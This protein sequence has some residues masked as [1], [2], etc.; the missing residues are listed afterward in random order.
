MD[1]HDLVIIGGGA[2]GFA[3]A[4]R[5]DDL[6]K[7][8]AIINDGLP[9]GGTCVNVGCVPSKKLLFAGEVL[10]AAG[11]HGIP[12]V[13]LA[14]KNL[15]FQRVVRDELS[16]VERMRREKYEDVPGFLSHVT[17]IEALPVFP[18]LSEALKIVALSFT[19]DIDHLSCCI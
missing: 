7:K 17:V 19:R 9:L 3:A 2:G 16:L 1:T 10:H 5:A 11:S 6:G 18:T 8:T 4:I 15:D 13:E 14:V 12:G